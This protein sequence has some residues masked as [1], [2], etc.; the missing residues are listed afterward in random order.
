LLSEE[1]DAV[2]ASVREH[3]RKLADFEE[4]EP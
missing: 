3:W 4:V 1:G 2:G